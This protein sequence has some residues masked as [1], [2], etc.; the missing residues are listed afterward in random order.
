MTGASLVIVPE[1]FGL[2]PP[3]LNS[4]DI[5]ESEADDDWIEEADDSREGDNGE[6][7]DAWG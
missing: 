4:N 6:E 1:R 3:Q 2:S 5:E 7:M